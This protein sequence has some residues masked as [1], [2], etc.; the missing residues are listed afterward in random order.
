[1]EGRIVEAT[2]AEATAAATEQ[3]PRL[4]ILQ[5]CKALLLTGSMPK[6]VGRCV[7]IKVHESDRQL[8]QAPT[9]EG[10]HLRPP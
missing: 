1:M 2:A 5:F 4:N 3:Q 8:R 7:R 9:V 6:A 10:A